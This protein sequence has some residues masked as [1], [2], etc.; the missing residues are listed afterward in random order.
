MAPGL[1]LGLGLGV[2]VRVRVRVSANPN[3]D[4][5]PNPNANPSLEEQGGLEE[6]HDAHGGV[7]ADVL[8]DRDRRARDRLDAAWEGVGRV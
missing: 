3:P 1:E 7:V 6:E 8:H 4:P 5:N 2:R